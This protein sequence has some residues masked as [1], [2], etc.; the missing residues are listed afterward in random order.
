MTSSDV[1]IKGVNALDAAGNVG[2]LFGHQGSWPVTSTRPVR[3]KGFSMIYPVG[4]EKLIPFSI[5]EAAK[6]AKPTKCEYAM[7][8]PVGLFPCPAGMTVNELRAIEM[9]SGARRNTDG[10]GWVGRRR[11]SADA[12]HK[13]A[14][15]IKW[16]ERLSLSSN[17]KEPSFPTC[18]S[19][20]VKI[21]RSPIAG[22]PR[23]ESRGFLCERGVPSTAS[24]VRADNGLTS[25][26]SYRL[27]RRLLERGKPCR[28]RGLATEEELY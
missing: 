24:Q 9:L 21:V 27:T 14:R 8:M 19:A 12:H 28:S 4:L 23:P 13:G 18:A 3:K 22:F 10:L 6:E 16:R 11:R 20:I 7:G 26:W 25:S 1:Y 2:I 15:A 5:R 17:Q